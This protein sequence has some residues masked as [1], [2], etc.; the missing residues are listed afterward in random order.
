M[1]TCSNI[2][3]WKIPR[4]KELVGYS[5]RGHKELDMTET[6]YTHTSCCEADKILQIH[7]FL[8]FLV[9]ITK[10]GSQETPGVTGKFGLGV[11]NEAGQRLVEFCQENALVIANTLFQQHKRRHYT[12][13]SPDGQHQNQTDY[14]LCSQ[15]WRSSMQSAR[16]RLGADCGLDHEFLIVKFRLIE[17]SGE[18]HQTIQV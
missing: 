17:E 11:R 9:S 12:R 14:I 18:N 16:T 4:R 13:T 8:F 3:A 15:R 6:E 10:V 1:A 5:L 7:T 2:L